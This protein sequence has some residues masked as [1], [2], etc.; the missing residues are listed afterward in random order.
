MDF[1]LKF[2]G[3]QTETAM[4]YQ[5]RFRAFSSLRAVALPIGRAILRLGWKLKG[6]GGKKTATPSD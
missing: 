4:F 6:T 5:S 3:Q 1:K 2:G